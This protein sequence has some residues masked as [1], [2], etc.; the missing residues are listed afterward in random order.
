MAASD[1]VSGVQVA[2]SAI[3]VV[4]VVAARNMAKPIRQEEARVTV[5][6]SFVFTEF[7]LESLQHLYTNDS[8]RKAVQSSISATA[9]IQPA[10]APS[11]FTGKQLN[12]KPWSGSAARFI[13]FSICQYG[14]IRP[15]L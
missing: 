4:A 12:V 6:G 14:L 15:A 7:Y 8:P 5:A 3:A 11:I 9:R 2:V 13:S 10:L 1:I